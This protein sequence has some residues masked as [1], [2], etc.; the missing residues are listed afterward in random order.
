[1]AVAQQRGRE[2]RVPGHDRRVSLPRLAAALAGGVAIAASPLFPW[3]HHGVGS[4]ISARGLADLALSGYSAPFVPL[5]AGLLVYLAPV[6]G[7]T[8]IIGEGIGR[9]IGRVISVSGLLLASIP[10]IALT[11]FVSD[12]TR[13]GPG[14]GMVIGLGGIVVAIGSQAGRLLGLAVSARHHT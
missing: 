1:M 2:A 4:A 11:F 13:G 5:W 8:I 9:R 10:I 7:A 12:V 3:A 14:P 6:G